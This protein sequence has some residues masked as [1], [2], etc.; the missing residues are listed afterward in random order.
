MSTSLKRLA[1]EAWTDADAMAV[2]V[3]RLL[4]DGLISPA[5][6]LADQERR[7]AAYPAGHSA[8][9]DAL[10]ELEVRAREWILA[11]FSDRYHLDPNGYS[12]PLELRVTGGWPDISF[13]V[14]RAY[15]FE[16]PGP[17]TPRVRVA[18]F[19]VEEQPRLLRTRPVMSDQEQNRILCPDC[20]AKVPPPAEEK[21]C[22]HGCRDAV[23]VDCGKVRSESDPY[24]H[25]LGTLSAS[26][27]S[28]PAGDPGKYWHRLGTSSTEA[29]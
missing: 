22:G 10:Y 24:W 8:K 17:P 25:C 16:P 12:T 1:E 20:F 18:V 9:D 28:P 14:C 11:L 15:K 5:A 23:C 21:S 19:G 2:L 4:S 29:L 6:L 7:V 3:D 27:Q 13:V 26:S